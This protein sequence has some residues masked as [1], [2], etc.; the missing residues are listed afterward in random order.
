MNLDQIVI[1]IFGVAAVWLSQ[2]AREKL[3]R[4]APV[5]GLIAQPAWIYT[6]YVHQQ[7]AIL[8]LTLFYTWA[9]WKGVRTYW[10]KGGTP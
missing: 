8:A 6:T 3:R 9:W 10:L 2:D 5:C 4:W 7:W 1:A